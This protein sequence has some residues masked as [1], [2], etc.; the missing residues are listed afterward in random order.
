MDI[1]DEI[2]FDEIKL[3]LCNIPEFASGNSD[4]E[5]LIQEKQLKEAK[6]VKDYQTHNEL[7]TFQVCKLLEG[8]LFVCF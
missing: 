2:C 3:H 5:Y 4:N 7:K 8:V 6:N 1:E